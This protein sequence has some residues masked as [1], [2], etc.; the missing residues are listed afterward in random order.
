M[1]VN[2]FHTERLK[3]CIETSGGKIICGGQVNVEARHVQPTIIL[4][5]K[6]DSE[7]MTQEI[8]GCVLPILPFSTIKEVAE[9]VN[10]KDKPLTVYYFGT[11]KSTNMNYLVKNTSSGHFVANDVLMQ[12]TTSYQG[13]GGVGAS[14]YGRH[15]GYEGFKCFSNR[16]GVLVKPAKTPGIMLSLM[17]PPYTN[18]DKIFRLLPTL[19]H[20]TQYELARA[21][22]F[23]I[24][25]MIALMAFWKF[26]PAGKAEEVSEF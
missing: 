3:R 24:F 18:I 26:Y 1:I 20:Y 17:A 2:K 25:L 23:M 16:K 21:I 22:A 12:F 13:F 4:E 9:F 15:G 6:K 11:P 7:L 10:S 14:G 5:P 8:F 19:F